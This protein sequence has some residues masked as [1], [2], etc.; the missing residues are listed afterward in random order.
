MVGDPGGKYCIDSLEVSRNAYAA[1]LATNP[2]SSG[3]PAYCGTN[4]SFDPVTTG[5][6]ANTLSAPGTAP[7]T[8]VDW[9]DARAFCE[10]NGKK[11]CGAIGGGTLGAGDLQNHMF[12]AWFAACS[13]DGMRTHPYG[14]FSAGK[15]NDATAAVGTVAGSPYKGGSCPGGF[16]G[17]YDM[18]GNAAE[19]I[20]SCG[21]ANGPNDQC[22]IMGGSYK[23]STA[24][25]L[26]CS[27]S[28]SSNRGNASQAHVGFRCCT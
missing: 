1:W 4:S 17:L 16:G 24:T 19:W 13:A 12:S 23:S 26:A 14:A 9:C 10:A 25:S 6:C 22:F 28:S 11:L 15:C 27:A 3:Q 20:D 5:E 21:G 7:Q 8:C 2:G 18:S